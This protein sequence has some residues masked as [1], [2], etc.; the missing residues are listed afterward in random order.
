MS[1]NQFYALIHIIGEQLIM[2]I[3]SLNAVMM[4]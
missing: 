3:P 1:I 2:N 4:A